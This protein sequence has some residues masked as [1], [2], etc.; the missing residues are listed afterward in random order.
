MT[1]LIAKRDH[2]FYFAMM[3]IAIGLISSID[4]Y[5]A[6]KNQHIMLYNEQNPIGRYLIRQDNGDVALFMGIKM[7]GT[8]LALGFLIFL[9]HHK[10]LYAWLSV[11]FLTIAQFLLLFYLGQ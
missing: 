2:K 1:K 9:Y 11:I 10:R 5:W 3:W 8:I 7:A 4:L 6:V